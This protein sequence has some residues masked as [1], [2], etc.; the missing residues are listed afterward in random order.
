MEKR[1]LR[2]EEGAST[3]TSGRKACLPLV[4]KRAVRAEEG[5]LQLP[6]VADMEGLALALRVGEVAAKP[7]LFAPEAGGGHGGEEGVDA[8]LRGW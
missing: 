4:E 5:A 7:L 2:A 1:A 8:H 3:P 6:V